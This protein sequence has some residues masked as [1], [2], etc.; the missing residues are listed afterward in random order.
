MRAR[1]LVRVYR[2]RSHSNSADITAR[3]QWQ[4]STWATVLLVIPWLSHIGALIF[5]VWEA[6]GTRTSSRFQRA[7]CATAILT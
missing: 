3:F 5:I 4:N 1:V 2:G 6:V 7:R